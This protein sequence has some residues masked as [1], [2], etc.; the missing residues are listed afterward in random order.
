[1]RVLLVRSATVAAKEKRAALT[2]KLQ[3]LAPRLGYLSVRRRGINVHEVWEDG[4]AFLDVKKRLAE[5]LE[6]REAIENARK[7]G[8]WT[9][10]S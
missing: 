1:M 10:E 5:L 8:D 7:V 3:M 4:E 6:L 9:P 2:R